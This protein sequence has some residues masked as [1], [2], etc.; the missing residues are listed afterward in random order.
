MA[1]WLESTT[2]VGGDAVRVAVVIAVS[3]S[4]QAVDELTVSQMAGMLV[5]RMTGKPVETAVVLKA[6]R[7]L[8]AH[9]LLKHDESGFRWVMTPLGTLVSRPMTTADIEPEG[10]EPLTTGETRA[11]RDRILAQLEQDAKL[12]DEAGVP[13]EELMA[14]QG[15]RLTELRVLNRVLA[16]QELPGWLWAL[17]HHVRKEEDGPGNGVAAPGEQEQT[18]EESGDDGTD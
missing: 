14:V 4:E 3:Q 17:A 13:R 5:Q 18:Q 7:D 10:N 6:I 1:S 15:A 12:I 9:G 16:E 11:W 8:A 2:F